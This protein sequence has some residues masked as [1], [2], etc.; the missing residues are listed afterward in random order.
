[1][2]MTFYRVQ[3]KMVVILYENRRH[4]RQFSSHTLI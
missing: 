1:M 3:Q 4:L 2:L